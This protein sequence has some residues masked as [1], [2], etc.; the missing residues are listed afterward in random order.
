MLHRWFYLFWVFLPLFLGPHAQV[1]ALVIITILMSIPGTALAIGFNALYAAAVPE[2]DRGRVAGW[3]NAAFALASIIA[4][5]ISGFLLSNLPFPL[6][7]QMVFGIGFLAALASSL[8]LRAL[9]VPAARPS[10]LHR[11]LGTLAAPGSPAMGN[12]PRFGLGLRAFMS[13][14]TQTV[15]RARA[16][17]HFRTVLL[18]VMLLYLTLF[19]GAP[20]FPLYF[21]EALELSD[22]WIGIGNGVFYFALFAGSFQLDRLSRR[23]GHRGALAL[24][25]S[26]IAFYPALLA[27]AGALAVNDGLVVYLLASVVGGVAWSLVFG[28]L[29]NYVLGLIPEEVRPTYLALHNMALQGGILAGSLLASLLAGWLGLTGAL[30]L[31]AAAR[32]G[33]G[34]LL[35]RWG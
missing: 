30:L 10:R 33:V 12:V 34:L 25:M 13:A 28:S 1:T 8:H 16:L 17:G 22:R 11:R 23:L 15:R 21:V 31:A 6:G 29:G 26:T 35:W 27:A 3:R 7:Y 24:G 4:T 14:G 5:V 20:L 9:N 2:A 32:A 18:L 19:L